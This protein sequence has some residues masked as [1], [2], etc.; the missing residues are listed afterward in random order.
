MNENLHK[1][2]YDSPIFYKFCF[3]YEEIYFMGC[4]FFNERNSILYWLLILRL[5]GL[6]SNAPQPL[7]KNNYCHCLQPV[8]QGCQ[9]MRITRISTIFFIDLDFLPIS[10][11]IK[12]T[13]MMKNTNA[14]RQTVNKCRLG[15]KVT[16]K[17][18]SRLT[19]QYLL[20][21]VQKFTAAVALAQQIIT[22]T[23]IE[24]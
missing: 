16:D 14:I 8:P 23:L 9:S 12:Y 10:T 20:I 18:L 3:L 21:F 6:Y 24:K 11:C 4:R 7:N 19:S 2:L 15:F 5:V 17:T 22:S 1:T 13:S